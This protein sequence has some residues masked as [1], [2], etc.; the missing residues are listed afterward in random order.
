MNSKF[1][2]E[3]F[4]NKY[5]RVKDKEESLFLLELIIKLRF[6]DNHNQ[7][8]HELYHKSQEI[9][10]FLNEYQKSFNLK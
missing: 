3:Q 6:Y 2:T 9:I 7:Y 10:R 4:E 8:S 1:S 5:Q